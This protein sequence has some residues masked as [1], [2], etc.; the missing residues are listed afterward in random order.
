M[1]WDNTV[2]H[3][4]IAER[5]LA[6][7]F[8]SVTARTAGFNTLPVGDM[9]NGALFLIII[10]MFIGASPGSC[11]GGIKTTT[12][13]CL[14]SLGLSRL[15][16][17]EKPTLFKRSISHESVGRAASITMVS[18]IVVVVGT[19]GL[20]VAETGSGGMLNR[21]KF[22]EIFFERNNPEGQKL[23]NL[24]QEHTHTRI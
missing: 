14:A 16:G 12:V 21:G 5:F 23:L 4:P 8:Q 20:L 3:F 18:I 1:E 22:I 24:V 6:G 11:G 9:S 7:I 17:I 13:A 2:S 19:M 15:K 10:L